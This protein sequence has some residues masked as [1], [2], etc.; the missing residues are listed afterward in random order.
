MKMR[1]HLIE[2]LTLVVAAVILASIAN[3]FASRD[4]SLA[5]VGD[6]PNATMV[7]NQLRA[8][9]ATGA[10]T[11]PSTESGLAPGMPEAGD[12]PTGASDPAGI[13]AP[14]EG[15]ATTS[16]TLFSKEDI[17]A[18]FPPNE[19][20][21]FVEVSGDNVMWLYAA[22]AMFLDA[23][24]TGVY[25]EGHIAGAHN[26]A[27]WEA[28]IDNKVSKLVDD[29]TDPEMPIVVYCSG[30]ACEDSHMLAQ[31]LWGVFFNNVLV[32]RDGYPDW[33]KRGGSTQKGSAP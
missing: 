22:G 30:G 6:Y 32:Y 25:E 26:F 7:P 2:T 18:R 12:L 13:E 24:R 21:P 17:L 9:G 19:N 23:R 14:A 11:Q 10:T 20:E 29:G 33:I 1:R 31:K 27:I 15:A 4:R 3:V 16:S 8:D 28:D 5:T